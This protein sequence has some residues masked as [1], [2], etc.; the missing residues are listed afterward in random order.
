M[1]KVMQYLYTATSITYCETPV[2][3][4]LLSTGFKHLN[5]ENLM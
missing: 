3:A 1:F 5:E 2:K 4:S